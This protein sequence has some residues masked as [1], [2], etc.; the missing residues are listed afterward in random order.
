MSTWKCPKCGHIKTVYCAICG[1][2]MDAG[3][4]CCSLCGQTHSHVNCPKCGFEYYY[5]KVE[6]QVYNTFKQPNL[7]INGVVEG[8]I[9]FYPTSTRDKYYKAYS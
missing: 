4:H 5:A 1:V 7:E 8:D 3:P 6:N 9:T 2:E